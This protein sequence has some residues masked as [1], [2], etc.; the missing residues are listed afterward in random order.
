MHYFF[1]FKKFLVQN[2]AGKCEPRM[3]KD[4]VDKC[5]TRH[6]QAAI[7]SYHLNHIYLNIF[8]VRTV[9]LVRLLHNYNQSKNDVLLQ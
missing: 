3:D 8:T 1:T 2:L 5:F 4:V 6:C 9:Y 7:K